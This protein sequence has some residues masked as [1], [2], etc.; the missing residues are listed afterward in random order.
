MNENKTLLVGHSSTVF[1][2]LDKLVL[3]DRLVYRGQLYR[4]TS[5]EM[6]EK[7]EISMMKL[8]EAEK[9]DTVVLMTCAGQD[10]GGGD[11][12]HRLIIEAVRV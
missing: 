12:S 5:I 7:K 8:L 2:D 6:H 4:V 3:D 1:R 9:V 11:A 10:L